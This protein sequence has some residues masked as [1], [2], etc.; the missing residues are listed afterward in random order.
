M[1][2]LHGLSS[3]ESARDSALSFTDRFASPFG[4]VQQERLRVNILVEE[5]LLE[6]GKIIIEEQPVLKS[7][8][9]IERMTSEEK[10]FQ[11]RTVMS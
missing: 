2:H 6:K 5:Q 3:Q 4:L 7:G 1:A 10:Q 8:H 11:E 9:S